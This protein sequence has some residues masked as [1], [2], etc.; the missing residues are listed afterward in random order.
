MSLSLIISANVP[1][2]KD[3]RHLNFVRFVKLEQLKTF[4]IYDFFINFFSN[5]SRGPLRLNMYW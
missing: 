4:E 1:V 2:A 3:S 5:I